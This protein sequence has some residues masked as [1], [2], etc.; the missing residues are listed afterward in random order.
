MDPTTEIK[1]GLP[2]PTTANHNG[3]RQRFHLSRAESCP[4]KPGQ[5]THMGAEIG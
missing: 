2:A 3:N 1:Y 4:D 5:L